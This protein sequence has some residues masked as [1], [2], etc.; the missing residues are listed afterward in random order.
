MI[1]AIVDGIASA[2]VE[3]L[4]Y[5]FAQRALAAGMLAALAGALLSVIVVWR[6]MAFVG[7]A[8]AHATLPGIVAAYVIGVSS[9]AGSIVAAVVAGIAMASIS[10]HGRLREDTAVGIVFSALFALG[11]LL[12]SRVAAPQDLSHAL[13][14]NIL[15][16][17]IR[18]LVWMATVVAIIVAT[19]LAGLK[20]ILVTSFD[21]AHAS[22][23]GID[24]NLIRSIL[25]ILLALTIVVAVRAVGIVLVL[26]LLVTPGAIGTLATRRIRLSI[27]VSVIAAQL[28]T[29]VGFYMS[30]WFDVAT[31]PII[32]LVLAAL[33]GVASLY[34][35]ARAAATPLRATSAGE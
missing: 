22:A 15:G 7:D 4:T 25:F 8:I 10:R 28:A 14:G 20:E 16:V 6:G 32:V 30:Y 23:I 13:F 35:S 24:P 1:S 2:L 33:F 19:M 11:I 21:P 26:A 31:G 3:P 29:V 17:T 34:R 18:D 5:A 12:M 9:M 27:V